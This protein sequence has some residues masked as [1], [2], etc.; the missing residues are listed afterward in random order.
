[1]LPES[2]T[3][4]IDNYINILE[5]FFLDSSSK[6]RVI[7]RIRSIESDYLDKLFNLNEQKRAWFEIKF[8]PDTDSGFKEYVSMLDY[9]TG[10]PEKGKLIFD[11][12]LLEYEKYKSNK[13]Q[14]G[15]QEIKLVKFLL[16]K[17]VL[18]SEHI[19]RLNTLKTSNRKLY[20]C[21]SRNP[22]D[23]LFCSTNQSFTS[24][25][26]LNSGYEGAFY[27]GLGGLPID[28]NRF[29]V[30]LSNSKLA[31]YTIK[32]YEFKHFKYASR[33]WGLIG[34]GDKLAIIK[35]YPSQILNI[36]KRLKALKYNASY[37]PDLDLP[38]TSKFKFKP[39]HY[40]DDQVSTIYLDEIGLT[41]DSSGEQ[42]YYSNRGGNIGGATCFNFG[43]GFEELEYFEDLDGNNYVCN[44]C[45]CNLYEGDIYWA[46]DEPYCDNCYSESYTGCYNCDETIEL[47]SSNTFYANDYAYC[48]RCFNIE[49]TT[50]NM[51]GNTIALD[52]SFADPD[53]NACC[54][55][56]YSD[57]FIICTD[58]GDTISNDDAN[59]L[60]ERYFCD[61]CFEN[62]EIAVN[63]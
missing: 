17:G 61:D 9:W 48:E 47:D 51:C 22:I 32:G 54:E 33:S 28:P 52:S 14:V 24:C 31:R 59:E 62:K 34:E 43:G 57:N 60:D 63:E 21:I 42:Y 49:F 26:S 13:I 29:L 50:C 30:F 56:C 12:N 27:M 20:M 40:E 11:Y 18:N 36:A 46:Y 44:N 2:N 7:D 55:D 23:Y 3:A 25:E 4:N 6:N 58:C 8:M 19:D 45:G 38:F 35:S 39:P 41:W 1:M 16:K 5:Y 37:V 15:K 10:S 53:G